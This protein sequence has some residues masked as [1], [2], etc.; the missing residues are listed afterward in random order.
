MLSADPSRMDWPELADTVS[1]CQR[2]GLCQGRNQTVF[3]VGDTKAQWLFIGEGPGYYENMQG[4]PFVGRAGQLLDNMLKALGVARGEAAYIANIVKCRPT[5]AAGKD[6][7]PTQEEIAACLP[8]LQRQIELI[9]PQI[10]VALGKTAALSLLG[11]E[12]QT[13]VGK[14]RGKVHYYG[15]IPLVVTWHP[16]YLL[17]Q[18]AEKRKTWVDLCLARDALAGVNAGVRV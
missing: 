12:P 16:A 9:Q 17:R 2:C 6:R 4:Q 3:G 15:A 10:M 11:L 14:L 18:P 13:P 1:R 7:P 8:Y 5:D